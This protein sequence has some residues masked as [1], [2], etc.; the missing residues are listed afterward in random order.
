[1]A[2][3]SDIES[4]GA[5]DPVMKAI[6]EL[7]SPSYEALKLLKAIAPHFDMNSVNTLKDG[8]GTTDENLRA[9]TVWQ[10]TRVGYKW[11]EEDLDHLTQDKS[12]KVRANIILALDSERAAFMQSDKNNLVK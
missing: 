2:K 8:L 10:L 5:N 12:W 6:K 4:K 1:M 3:P 11:P 9:Y 7:F